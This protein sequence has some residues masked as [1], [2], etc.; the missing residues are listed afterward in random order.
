MTEGHKKDLQSVTA[1]GLMANALASGDVN[2]VREALRKKNLEG[3]IQAAF[4]TMQRVQ[5]T[6]R[7]S[8][9]ERDNL[10]PQFQAMRLWNGCSSL[11][12]TL[13]PHD[14]RSPLTMICCME[15]QSSRK[16]IIGSE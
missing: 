3:P 1:T 12:F 2:S 7:G 4:Q 5:R 16:K 11:L 14:I 10:L 13:N 9:A 8:E 6:V 15:I